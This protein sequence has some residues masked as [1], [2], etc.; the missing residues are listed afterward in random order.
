[1][2]INESAVFGKQSKPWDNDQ[3]YIQPTNCSTGQLSNSGG[4]MCLVAHVPL[5]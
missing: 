3:R 4:V 2:N 1:M 5:L